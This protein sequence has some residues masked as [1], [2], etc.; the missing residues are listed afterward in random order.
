MN[1]DDQTK[2]AIKDWWATNPMTYGKEHGTTSY[3]IDSQREHVDLGSR[4]FFERA[5]Q[6]FYRWNKSLHSSRAPFANIF[7]YERYRGSNVLEVGCGMGFMS[8]NW[9]K[10][11]AR[12]VAADLNPVAV[13][14][15][16]HRFNLYDVQ[17]S[18]VQMDAEHLPYQDQSFSYCYSWGVIHHTPGIQLAI[19]E[20]YRLLKPGGEIGLMLY[21]RGSLMYRY[22]VDYVEG[23]LHLEDEFLS[24]VELASRYGDGHLKEGNPHTWPVTHQEVQNTLMA[25][26]ENVK[27]K[28][29]GTEIGNVLDFFIPG[30]GT[31]MVPVAMK[32]ALARRWGWSLWITGQKP[33]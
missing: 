27:I 12:V 23:F 31:Y 6:T 29:L 26:F 10:Q 18:V 7:N 33:V 16:R 32:K 25:E 14:Q 8:M 4:E 22:L 1:K 19:N 30:L 20:M 28:V 17:G 24:S 5:D 13:R 3:Q 21:N 11:G 2:S 15:T 9:S